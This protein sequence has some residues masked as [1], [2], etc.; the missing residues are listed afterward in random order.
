MLIALTS[1]NVRHYH[2]GHRK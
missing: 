1:L 2:A